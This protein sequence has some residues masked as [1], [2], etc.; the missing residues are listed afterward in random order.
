MNLSPKLR[1]NFRIKAAI[2]C[3]AAF[4]LKNIEKFYYMSIIYKYKEYK[5]Q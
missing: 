5:I 4:I 2:H 1:H 3:I